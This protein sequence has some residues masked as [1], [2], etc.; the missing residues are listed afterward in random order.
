MKNTIEKK[1]NT[2]IKQFNENINSHV[3][4]IETNN[5][6]E[7]LAD[8]KEIIKKVL[9]GD[10]ITNYQIDNESYIELIVIRNEGKEILT[11]QIKYLLEK[12]KTR[13]ILSNYLFYIIVDSEKLN[14]T[15]ANKL[16][17]TIEEPEDGIIGFLITS[18]IEKI[19]PTIKSRCEI[20]KFDYEKESIEID[21]DILNECTKLIEKLEDN[22]LSSFNI[23]KLN[24]KLLEDN[25][26]DIINLLIQIYNYVAL[27]N[28]I[29]N[30]SNIK[31]Y[32]KNKNNQELLLK[33]ILYLNNI[34]PLNNSNMNKDLLL[35]KIF[36]DFKGM[37]Q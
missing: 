36:I 18:N 3:F 28:N 33:K 32:I 4:L 11:E 17:K 23:F 31:E 15:A 22:S 14:V 27:P 16:L 6:T 1:T 24:N 37:E 8:V 29:G 35:E 12:L 10:D 26:N 25:Y 21:E 30:F 20:L 2:I 9:D 19:L 5:K 7:C 34:V 13:P